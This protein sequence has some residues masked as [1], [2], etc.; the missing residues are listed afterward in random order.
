MD[1]PTIAMK[2]SFFHHVNFPHQKKLVNGVVFPAKTGA[3][4]FFGFPIDSPSDFTEVVEAT[5]FLPM[6][7]IGGGA[8]RTKVFSRV[9]KAAK[10]GMKLEWI[11]DGSD[12]VKIVIG[13]KPAFIIDNGRGRKTWFN[14]MVTERDNMA[15]I[16][17]EPVTFGNGEALPADVVYD[18]TSVSK[19][20]KMN[21][22]LFDG[23]KV[24]FY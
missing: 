18:N 15:V 5:G 13:L 14:S 9:Y 7:Y 4:L 2:E 23:R 24:M 20:W 1:E 19:S 3:I 21:V 8:F 12:A 11:D 22:W 6:E 17:P 16:Q 10:V